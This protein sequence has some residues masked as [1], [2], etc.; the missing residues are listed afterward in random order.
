MLK[1][2]IKNRLFTILSRQ[3]FLAQ[4][5]RFMLRNLNIFCSSASHLLDHRRQNRSPIPQQIF[6][7]EQSFH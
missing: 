3:R 2:K 4:S 6:S 1:L 5:G 7:R